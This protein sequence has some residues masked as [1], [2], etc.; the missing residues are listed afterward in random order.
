MLSLHCTDVIQN[1]LCL[2]GIQAVSMIR[3]ESH[4]RILSVVFRTMFTA[5]TIIWK[6]ILSQS[7]TC[8]SIQVINWMHSVRVVQ[9]DPCLDTGE[10]KPYTGTCSTMNEWNE[11]FYIAKLLGG[12]SS[13]A[14]SILFKFQRRFEGNKHGRHQGQYIIKG[15]QSGQ[16]HLKIGD[17]ILAS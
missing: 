10:N 13:E 11:N 9:F 14:Q 8:V 4:H 16:S 5:R 2:L 6:L 1:I 3:V 7:W 15:T 17:F 12:P